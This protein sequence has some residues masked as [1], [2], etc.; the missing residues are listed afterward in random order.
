MSKMSKFL[1]WVLIAL[2]ID[3]IL[4]GLIAI[5]RENLLEVEIALGLTIAALLVGVYIAFKVRRLSVN[6]KKSTYD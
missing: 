3:V 6:S 5:E 2:T 1:R 4:T